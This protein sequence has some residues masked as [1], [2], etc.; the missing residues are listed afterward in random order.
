MNY[1]IITEKYYGKSAYIFNDGELLRKIIPFTLKL[2]MGKY[3]PIE[4][5]HDI[6][7]FGEV[8]VKKF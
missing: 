8:T 4:D 6:Y 7:V 3:L 1:V 5:L 2:E